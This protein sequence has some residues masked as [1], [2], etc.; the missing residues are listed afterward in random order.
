MLGAARKSEEKERERKK[1]KG[2]EGRRCERERE[3]ERETAALFSFFPPF[4]SFSSWLFSHPH[5]PAYPHSLEPEPKIQNS[6][7]RP[8]SIS[9]AGRRPCP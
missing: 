3:G 8:P 7:S 2:G 4:F 6:K 9:L 1:R 5:I